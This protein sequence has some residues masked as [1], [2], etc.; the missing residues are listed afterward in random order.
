MRFQQDAPSTVAWRSHRALLCSQ[1]EVRFGI[2]LFHPSFQFHSHPI[3]PC[4][5]AEL[6]SAGRSVPALLQRETA[7]PR[8]ARSRSCGA[9]N[10]GRAYLQS[11]IFFVRCLSI[12]IAGADRVRPPLTAPETTPDC[13]NCRS[14]AWA[15][16][17]TARRRY[18]RWAHGP[19]MPALPASLPC[20]PLHR[21]HVT[22]SNTL[23]EADRPAP[24]ALAA[25]APAAPREFGPEFR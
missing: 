4:A 19:V 6:C 12:S 7:P 16:W 15:K 2:F 21:I 3:R 5:G 8:H 14:S 9:R 11:M 24:L 23:V 20:W 18:G 10:P 22:P 1:G 25:L 17:G 13:G